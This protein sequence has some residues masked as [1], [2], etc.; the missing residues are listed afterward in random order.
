MRRRVFLL[1]LTAFSATAAFAGE[2]SAAPEAMIRALYELYDPARRNDGFVPMDH[3]DTAIMTIDLAQAYAKV[4]KAPPGEGAQLDWDLFVNGQDHY[5]VK[6]LIVTSVRTRQGVTVTAKFD[7]CGSHMVVLYDFVQ[8]D[9]GWR[10]G[11]VRYPPSTDTPPGHF[12]LLA[13]AREPQ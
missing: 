7:N 10:L 3:V 9:A 11:D 12:S 8:T 4:R 5:D 1:G 6:N 2:A 13:F